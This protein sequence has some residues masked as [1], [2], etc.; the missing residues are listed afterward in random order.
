MTV[1]GLTGWWVSVRGGGGCGA[2]AAA[3]K[4]WCVLQWIGLFVRGSG[5]EGGGGAL[6][7]H[8][9]FINTR[10]KTIEYR[11]GGTGVW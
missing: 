4:K 2:A 8:G 9:S 6:E 5:G 10:H 11:G 1:L 7:D 3:S